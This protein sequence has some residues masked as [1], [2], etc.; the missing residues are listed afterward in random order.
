[1]S[2]VRVENVG[3]GVTYRVLDTGV[4]ALASTGR[5]NVSGVAGEED[6]AIVELVYHANARPIESGVR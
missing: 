2:Y 4:Q 1:M 3:E 6:A 5:V